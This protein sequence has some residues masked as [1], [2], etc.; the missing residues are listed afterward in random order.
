MTQKTLL[1][2][3]NT[4]KTLEERKKAIEKQMEVIQEEVKQE[5]QARGKEEEAVGD[6]MVRFKAVVNN[7]FNSKAF[8]AEH[9]KLYQKYLAPSQTMRFTVV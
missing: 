9:P 4:L 6:W 7:R 3:V 8:A 2:K 1:K 5:L